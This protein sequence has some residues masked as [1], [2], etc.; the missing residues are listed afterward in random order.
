L[1]FPF[2]PFKGFVKSP[3]KDK[4]NSFDPFM[5]FVNSFED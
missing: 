1:A 2:N 5:A 4:D 3:F